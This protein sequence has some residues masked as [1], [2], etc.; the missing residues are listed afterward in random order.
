MT[1]WLRR[2]VV[3]ASL[4]VA[5]LHGS[6]ANADPINV[7]A[8]SA[9]LRWDAGPTSVS[10]SGPNLLISGDGTGGG[11]T[12][13]EAGRL[14]T[15]DGSFTFST[16]QTPFAA[17]I[18]GI[19]YSAF[20]TGGLSFTTLPFIVPAADGPDAGRF[21]TTFGMAGRVRGYGSAERNGTPLFD[22]DLV[23]TG[24]ASTVAFPV[25]ATSLYLSRT[26]V[27]YEFAPLSPT[28]EP[29]TMALFVIGLAGFV[30]QERIRTRLSRILA[31]P[32]ARQRLRG[33]RDA[34]VRSPPAHQQSPQIGIS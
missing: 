5:G 10:L 3:L 13:W 22:V 14:G 33:S 8:G 26:G 2:A 20:L 6:A 30:T 17:T 23:G 16:V 31:R 21:Q 25:P 9:F 4:S 29:G 27:D 11:A 15:L 24:I 34:A 19:T 7:T 18:D 32:L 28:P 12:G 1:A